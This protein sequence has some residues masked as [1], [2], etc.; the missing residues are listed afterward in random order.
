[1]E[2]G[3]WREEDWN[4]LIYTITQGNCILML[5]PDASAEQIDGQWQPL[6]EQLSQELFNL[7]EPD[8]Q[9]NIEPTNFAQV[10]QYYELSKKRN[11]LNAK[12]HFFYKDKHNAPNDL[13]AKLAAL[14]FHLTLTSTPDVKFFEALQQ[15]RKDPVFDCYNFRGQKRMMAHEGT[16]ER[17]LVFHLYGVLT[18]PGSLVLT[19]IDLID[20]LAAVIGKNPPLPLNILSQLRDPNKS[21]LFL[22]FGF[23][24]WYLRILLHVLQGRDKESG[25]FALEQCVP[26]NLAE[27]RQTIL[28]FSRSR[29]NIQICEQELFGF[30]NELRQRYET[31]I[32][33]AGTNR[34]MPSGPTLFLCCA[35]EQ[36]EYAANLSEQLDAA[37]FRIWQ[38]TREDTLTE[39][40]LE[41][42]IHDEI[43]YVVV[44]QSLAL[45][46]QCEGSF[47]EKRGRQEQTQ[48]QEQ[49]DLLTQKLSKIERA[50]ILETN[51]GDEFRYEN[52]IN[53]IKSERQKIAQ[54]LR[55]LERPAI[56]SSGQ[57]FCQQV[58]RFALECQQSVKSGTAFIL[59]VKIDESPGLEALKR[60]PSIDLSHQENIK[61]LI[62]AIKR[63]QERRKRR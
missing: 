45:T 38:T 55:T 54:Q 44:L 13:Y 48:L 57:S 47:D 12:I 24:H 29:Y 62:S 5:G 25:S 6:T 31:H 11:A 39:T 2:C 9:A 16:V 63:D 43:D 40:D 33:S 20:F 35:D 41:R 4:T 56:N 1:M 46:A 34:Y 7:L 27:F 14:P 17:P 23:K 59:S 19:E 51:P 22:G 30:V 53:D 42:A 50:K 8:L 18:E 15:A 36:S 26:G 28:F 58:I 49:W 3:A 61:D 21:I 52:E 32:A 10:A 60:L 37:G